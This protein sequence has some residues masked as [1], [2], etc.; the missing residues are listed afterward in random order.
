M[1]STAELS[2]KKFTG[3]VLPDPYGQL[4]G[5]IPDNTSGVIWGPKGSGKSTM[6]VDFAWVMANEIGKGIYCSSEEGPGPSMQGKINR[7]GAEHDDLMVI[8]FDGRF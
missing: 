4:L 1:I 6:A 3:T 8:D 7:L 2:K 5:K